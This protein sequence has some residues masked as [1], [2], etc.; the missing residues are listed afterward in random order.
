[1]SAYGARCDPRAHA[2]LRCE[3]H[4]A[5]RKEIGAPVA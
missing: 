5:N 3:G 1:M 4:V 2:V